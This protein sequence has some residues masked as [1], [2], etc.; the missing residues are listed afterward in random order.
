M[1]IAIIGGGLSGLSAAC[2]LAGKHEVTIIEEKDFLGG[3][4]S[5]YSIDWD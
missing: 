4:A 3:M 2:R 1:K 5:S